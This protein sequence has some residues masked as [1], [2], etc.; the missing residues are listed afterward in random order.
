MVNIISFFQR[1]DPT[2]SFEALVAPHIDLLY[3]QAYKYCGHADEAED[4][5]QSLLA[6]LFEKKAD[7]ASLEEPKHWLVK[8]LYHHFIDSTRKGKN[9]PIRLAHTD[10]VLAQIK[11]SQ[12][13]IEQQYLVHSHLTSALGKL[14]ADHRAVLV[15]H[16]MEGYQLT[17]IAE[18]IDT[19][20]GTL[21]SRLH[22]ARSQL[23]S[24]LSMEPLAEA[25]RVN[26]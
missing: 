22:R 10:D 12:T 24:Q 9:D 5:V 18:M 19:P 23:R 21:K 15:L 8:S 3:K 20:V 13:Q 4:L 16:D 1:K 17:E 26:G 11:D 25:L 14:S 2:N 6:K 7:L